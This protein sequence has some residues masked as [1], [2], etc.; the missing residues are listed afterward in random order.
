[1]NFT[2]F[3]LMLYAR[4]KIV[5]GV[6]LAFVVVAVTLGLV[7]P[8]KYVAS[9]ALIVDAKSK[10]P[11]SGQMLPAQVFPGYLGTQVEMIESVGVAS[12]VVRSLGLDKN[13]GVLQAFRNETGGKGDIVNWM[14]N[15][16]L[17][18]LEVEPSRDSNIISVRYKGTD[19]EFAAIIANGFAK[20]YVETNL[21]LRLAPARESATWMEQQVTA[22]RRKV[23]EA[24]QK[25][26][27]YQREN[28]LVETDERLDVETRRLNDISA[29]I[30]A[31]Q[32]LAF[33]A[34]SRVRGGNASTEVMNSPVVQNIKIQVAQGDS[35]LAEMAKRLGTNH[36]DYQRVL[37][38]VESLRGKLNS[39]LNAASRG[40]GLT[41][42][43]ARSTLADLEA[44]FAKQ[45]ERVLELKAQ[46]EQASLLTSEVLN[47]Q[48]IYD[49]SMQRFSQTNM[50]S[51]TTQTDIAVLSSAIPP[52][53]HSSP[54]VWLN[55]LIGVFLGTIAGVGLGLMVE[56]LDRRLRSKHDITDTLGIPLLGVMR[57][58]GGSRFARLLPRRLASQ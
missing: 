45:K 6:L 2:Q 48:R 11:L 36:P 40:V 43:A 9:T 46:R 54:N 1:M 14:A 13:P 41:A 56:L 30:V 18:E 24:Q 27:T 7:M 58:G 23:D 19:P 5:L 50:E 8:K 39:E 10:D 4:K 22:M 51:Q 15:R 3:L 31:A 44:T 25:L 17:R 20:A 32:S 57:K 53:E 38:E 28:N 52:S 26:T 12:R 29:Q 33:D 16:M 21:E 34:N 49:V 55:L 37:A 35:K 47:A 42:T